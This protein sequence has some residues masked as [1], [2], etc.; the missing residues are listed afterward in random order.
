MPVPEPLPENGSNPCALS[1]RRG[2]GHAPRPLHAVV[3]RGVADSQELVRCP[4]MGIGRRFVRAG[5]SGFMWLALFVFLAAL[6]MWLRGTLT[7]RNWVFYGREVG[8][9]WVALYSS[10]EDVH[11]Y[12]GDTRLPVRMLRWE[13]VLVP[14]TECTMGM[15]APEAR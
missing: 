8:E 6:A 14:S 3:T 4:D 13:Y 12:C 15:G 1:P 9:H 2:L 11:F 7:G 10:T 5:L